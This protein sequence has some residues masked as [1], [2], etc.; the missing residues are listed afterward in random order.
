MGGPELGR[1][2]VNIPLSRQRHLGLLGIVRD[3]RH[4]GR[5]GF[6]SRVDTDLTR[7]QVEER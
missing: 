5:V 4:G 2:E 7:A 1:D 3:E 6:D